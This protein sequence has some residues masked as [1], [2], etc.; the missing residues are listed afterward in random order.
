MIQR[1]AHKDRY[2][3]AAGIGWWSGFKMDKNSNIPSFL[4]GKELNKIKMIQ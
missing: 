1:I 4:L 3:I 2:L